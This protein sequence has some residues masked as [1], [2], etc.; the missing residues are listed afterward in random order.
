MPAEV[1]DRIHILSLRSRG[2]TAGFHI[3]ARNGFAIPDDEE[4]EFDPDDTSWYPD[5]DDD[6]DDDNLA[7]DKDHDM[8]FFDNLNDQ[9]D[10]ADVDLDPQPFDDAFVVVAG[11]DDPDKELGYDHYLA[12]IAGV[13]DEPVAGV[14]D[15]LFDNENDNI[16]AN[17][18]NER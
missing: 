7:S 4:A 12:D 2:I 9:E 6:A 11:D 3:A 15:E 13:S 17:I 18:R 16:D 8:A 1:I 10:Q 14:N 5:P